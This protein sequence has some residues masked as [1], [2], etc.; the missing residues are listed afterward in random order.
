MFLIN[1]QFA[2]TGA[3]GGKPESFPAPAAEP[4]HDFLVEVFYSKNPGTR[5]S[6]VWLYERERREM[7]GFVRE[8]ARRVSREYSILHPGNAEQAINA[9]LGRRLHK[10]RS[11]GRATWS[12]RVEVTAPDQV[13]AMMREELQKRYE[14]E[15]RAGQNELRLD[16]TERLHRRWTGF[17]NDAAKNPIGPYALELAANPEDIAQ[18]LRTMLKERHKDTGEWLT[19]VARIV[20]AHRDAG[21]L[22]LVVES[23]SVL[24]RTLEM[25]G[26]ELPALDSEA[27]PIPD[28]EGR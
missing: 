3:T 17:L 12:A 15:S 28:M 26:I 8:T 11:A 22:D 19:L 4:A 23:N 20:E 27:L 1:K 21:I 9:E 18:V 7:S 25:M 24:R 5:R 6:S 2:D 10:G 14:I 13:R 16:M